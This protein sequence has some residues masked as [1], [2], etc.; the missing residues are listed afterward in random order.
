MFLSQAS[1]AANLT[2]KLTSEPAIITVI[3][4]ATG[5]ALLKYL[6][7]I[8]TTFRGSGLDAVAERERANQIL[9]SLLASTAL[10]AEMKS[11]LESDMR[12]N[13][14]IR[15]HFHVVRNFLSTYQLLALR[16]I[17]HLE[18]YLGKRLTKER[19]MLA[20]ASKVN[21]DKG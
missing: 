11:T 19:E 6:P 7:A 2:D 18:N 4:L 20:D 10:M 9:S 8:I 17:E 3:F 21:R 12:E 5:V 13:E 16:L 14:Q 1:E 15:Q